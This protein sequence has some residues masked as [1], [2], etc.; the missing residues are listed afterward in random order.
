MDKMKNKLIYISLLII[1][2][3]LAAIIIT[4]CVIGFGSS[5]VLNQ[6]ADKIEIP[7]TRCTEITS[8]GSYYLKDN[9]FVEPD[10][11]PCFFISASNVILNG[12]GKIIYSDPDKDVAI[13][14]EA[15]GFQL[16]NI[17][18]R[19]ALTCLYTGVANNLMISNSTFDCY[20][21]G[22]DL[23]AGN[24]YYLNNNRIIRGDD[25]CLYAVNVAN[26]QLVNNTFQ[27]CE[28]A[29]WL[30]EVNNSLII[31]NKIYANWL[32][33]FF[34]NPGPGNLVFN[35][36][37]KTRS[38]PNYVYIYDNHNPPRFNISKQLGKNIVNGPFMGGNYYGKY[39][40]Q[41]FSDLCSD[42]NLDGLCDNP[43]YYNGS[44]D[45]LPLTKWN[46]YIPRNVK[47][48]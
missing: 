5:A 25:T 38:G 36:Y 13:D 42:N 28:D 46:P 27:D 29:V 19:S 30:T 41:G 20:E 14:V 48:I 6:P 43:I 8:P 22:L 31:S 39:N 9:I 18:I 47:V 37:L 15:N 10:D 23:G 17:E 2:A 7:L 3:V 16:K 12:N 21:N 26:L 40:L 44:V 34:N 35:N 24:S 1:C 4:L 11:D 32:P 45:M 33:L